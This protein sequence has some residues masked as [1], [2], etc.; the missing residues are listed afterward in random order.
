MQNY[1]NS[2][3]NRDNEWNIMPFSKKISVIIPALNEEEAIAKVVGDM[4]ECVSQVIVV[5]NASVDDTAKVAEGA[6][7]KAIFEGRRGYGYAC[8]AGIKAL[9][10]PDIVVFMDGDYSDDPREIEKLVEP[11]VEENFDFVM[12][13]RILG[14]REEGA[15][16]AHS[17]LANKLF[18]KLVYLLYGLSLSDIGSFKAIRYASLMALDMK[19]TSYGFP[20]EMVV[21]S[22]KRNL[23]IKEVPVRVRKRIGVSKVT[24][25]LFASVK[26]GFK[27]I[28]IIFRYSLK[29]V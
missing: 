28:Y 3:L 1:E 8:L 25:N 2:L 29:R 17:I 27:I 23:R 19:D 20:M 15:L 12:G 6:G 18:A 10:D 14:E 11:I 21:K 13:S 4:P 7:A 9:E 22:A 16:P 26:A 24:G 5:D